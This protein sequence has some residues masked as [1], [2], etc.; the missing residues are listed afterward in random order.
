MT[1]TPNIDRAMELGLLPK[2]AERDAA[3]FMRYPNGFAADVNNAALVAIGR[4]VLESLAAVA[5]EQANEVQRTQSDM[6]EGFGGWVKETARSDEAEALLNK[7]K[8]YVPNALWDEIHDWYA[9]R[10][11]EAEAL[12][13][14]HLEGISRDGGPSLDEQRSAW[15]KQR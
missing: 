15:D 1:P 2:E 11:D 10:A 7:A 13:N 12:N 8:A 14:G 6:R 9:R 4:R 5:V 3:T